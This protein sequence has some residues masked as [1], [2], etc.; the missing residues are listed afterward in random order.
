MRIGGGGGVGPTNWPPPDWLNA[1]D[2][3]DPVS[4]GTKGDSNRDSGTSG[5][6]AGGGDPGNSSER[7]NNQGGDNAGGKGYSQEDTFER[8]KGE[9]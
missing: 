2:K 6:G 3:P 7:D 8:V 4:G 9:I 1:W 5:S